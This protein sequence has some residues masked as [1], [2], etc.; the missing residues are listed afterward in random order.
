MSHVSR[1]VLFAE[2]IYHTTEERKKI[3]LYT[4]LLSV[5]HIKITVNREEFPNK[6]L[7]AKTTVINKFTE[8]PIPQFKITWIVNGKP[9]GHTPE[10]TK[11]FPEIPKVLNVT[12]V[13]SLPIPEFQSVSTQIFF[14][15]TGE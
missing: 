2:I 14:P 11:V 8:Q 4:K 9:E 10:L 12:V 15:Q 6:K 5:S 3:P 7:V 1:L 13:A